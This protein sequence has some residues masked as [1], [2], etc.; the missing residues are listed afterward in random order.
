MTENQ[1]NTIY[2]IGHSNHPIDK[3]SDA[4]KKHNITLLVDVRSHP[5]SQTSYLEQYNRSKLK[6]ELSTYGIDYQYMGDTLG[7]RPSDLSLYDEEGRADY[8][9]M[10][11]TEQ[12]KESID[13]IKKLSKK[14][15]IAL[16]CLEEDPLN[17]HRGI[18]LGR[19]LTNRGLH[20]EHIRLTARRRPKNEVLYE[21]ST[22]NQEELSQRLLRI[23]SQ[24]SV[25]ES[26][27]RFNSSD[28]TEYFEYFWEKR[29]KSI[30]YQL[31]NGRKQSPSSFAH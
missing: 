19:E 3:L 10:A 23:E 27:N 9:K 16:M 11:S 26:N 15:V 12:F 21:D 14:Y 6:Q 8:R 20:V 22:E 1:P 25:F 17:C 4:L 29:W 28:P 31:N 24:L 30:A 5:G 13:E 2:T 18:L 7:G